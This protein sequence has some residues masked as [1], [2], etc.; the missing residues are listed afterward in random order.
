M[1][2]KVTKIA[3]DLCITAAHETQRAIIDSRTNSMAGALYISALAAIGPIQVM[4]SIIGA[5]PPGKDPNDPVCRCNSDALLFSALLINKICPEA[6]EPNGG[7]EAAFGPEVYFQALEAFEKMTGRRP[8][9]SLQKEL[10]ANA[11]KMADEAAVPLS[12]F[13][14]ARSASKTQ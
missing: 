10:T 12:Q 9:D 14:T 2:N 11:R 7:N 13:M 1:D 4:A 8:D 5:A 3:G 6:P